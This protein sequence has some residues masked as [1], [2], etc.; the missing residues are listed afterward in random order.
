M[1]SLTHSEYAFRCSPL[2]VKHAVLL[3]VVF[4][5]VFV[6]LPAPLHSQAVA[7]GTIQGTVTDQSHA[8]V[9]GAAITLTDTSTNTSRTATSNEA[10]RYVFVDVPPGTYNLTISKTGFRLTKFANQVVTVATSLTLDVVMEIGSIAETVEVTAGAGAELQT[11][12][13]TV[14]TTIQHDELMQLPNLGRD[15]TTLATLQPGTNINGNTAGAVVDQNTFQLDGG[16]ITDDM[17]GDSNVYT[18]SFSSDVS[19]VGAYHS[20]GNNAAPSG[21]IPTPVESIEEFRVGV[22]NQ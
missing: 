20:P 9:A 2:P 10:G 16:S 4:L 18:L 13:S 12:N 17:S 19:G 8:A 15:A 5:L 7:T 1:L 22:A 14:G 6:A 11:M 3:L 21:V